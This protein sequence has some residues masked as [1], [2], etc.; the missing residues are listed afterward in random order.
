[1]NTIPRKAFRVNEAAEMYGVSTSLIYKM[2]ARGDLPD[3]RFAGCR[4]IPADAL[5][6][7]FQFNAGALNT[8]RSARQA[9]ATKSK[10]KALS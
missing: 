8:G 10:K 6:A 3:C 1:M 7:A 9:V 4:V 5:D 2:L